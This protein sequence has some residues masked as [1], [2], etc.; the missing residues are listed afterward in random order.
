MKFN[1]IKCSAKTNDIKIIEFA[2]R[3]YNITGIQ[4]RDYGWGNNGV[5]VTSKKDCSLIIYHH[6]SRQSN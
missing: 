1:K 5:E 6:I 3:Q 2:F 4:Y